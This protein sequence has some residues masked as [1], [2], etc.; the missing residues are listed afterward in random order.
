MTSH[1]HQQQAY[2]LGSKLAYA[3]YASIWFPK[4]KK[5]VA[6]DNAIRAA[7]I[8]SYAI[9]LASLGVAHAGH[10]VEQRYTPE[11]IRGNLE[12]SLRKAMN[13]SPELRVRYGTKPFGA[14]FNPSTNTVNVA[15]NPAPSIFAHEMGHA[16]GKPISNRLYGASKIL[17]PGTVPLSLLV[18]GFTDPD[19]PTATVARYTP[20]VLGAPM[21]YEEARASLRGLKALHQIGGKGAVIRGL[22]P[23]LGA[24]GTYGA[25][26]I[27]PIVG[28]KILQHMMHQKKKVEHA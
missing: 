16:T 27:S 26:A 5:E 25:T 13:A 28:G 10:A 23:L 21:L 19:S 2:L 20:G 7:N 24:F 4:T 3:K 17:G 6:R 18:Q 8:T 1:A 15:H 22:L 14:Y 11:A 9:P 12:A